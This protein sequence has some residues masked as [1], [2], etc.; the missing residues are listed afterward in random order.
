MIAD[1]FDNNCLAA[2]ESCLQICCDSVIRPFSNL[3]SD[4][5][6]RREPP[7]WAT[8]CYALNQTKQS[9]KQQYS[10]WPLSLLRTVGVSSAGLCSSRTHCAREE[11]RPPYFYLPHWK[12]NWTCSFPFCLS[13]DRNTTRHLFL[14]HLSDFLSSSQRICF[15]DVRLTSIGYN[16]CKG[17]LSV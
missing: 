17:T 11:Q 5:F 7:C 8:L 13:G 14:T 16:L 2:P 9:S 12:T 1:W 3:I 15:L 10:R 6:R 4:R